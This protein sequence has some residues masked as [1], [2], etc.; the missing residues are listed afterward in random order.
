MTD[1]YSEFEN[2]W[3]DKVANRRDG[4]ALADVRARMKSDPAYDEQ[5]YRDALFSAEAIAN[6]ICAFETR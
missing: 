1:I 6:A 3:I 2:A 4:S 5:K